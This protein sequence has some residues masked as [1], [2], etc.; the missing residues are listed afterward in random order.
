[1]KRRYTTTDGQVISLMC[2]RFEDA[3]AEGRTDAIVT[4]H[5]AE[6]VRCH[7]LLKQVQGERGAIAAISM[8]SG[9]V[10]LPSGFTEAV[11][12]RALPPERYLKDNS[13]PVARFK[14]WHHAVTGLVAGVCTALLFWAGGDAKEMM[15]AD[16]PSSQAVAVEE[17]SDNLSLKKLL[18]MNEDADE[19]ALQMERFER[20]FEEKSTVLPA[21]SV[22]EAHVDLP[23]ELKLAVLRQVDQNKTCPKRLKKPV[24]ITLTVGKNGGLS[25]RTVYSMANQSMAHDCVNQALDALTL[26]PMEQSANITLDVAW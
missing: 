14:W 8:A 20:L 7:M 26:P 3:L 22:P 9:P 13:E 15:E 4:E 24:R 25:N 16:T 17:S 6:C 1:M 12:A 21:V 5:A 11:L 10:E 2:A 23:K 18:G 19:E